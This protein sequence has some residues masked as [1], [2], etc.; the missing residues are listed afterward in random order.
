MDDWAA[1]WANRALEV[2]VT[3]SCGL[4]IATKRPVK[5][6]THVATGTIDIDR[7]D[8]GCGYLVQASDGRDACLF[9]P[10]ALLNAACDQCANV[11]LTRKGDT[12]VA[13]TNQPIPAGKELYACYTQPG[14]SWPCPAC[15]CQVG[16]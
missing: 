8:R 16:P 11:A 10:A 9:G 15:S 13:T 3:R 12:Y 5:A 1:L 6:N 7:W 14:E 4:G 2:R